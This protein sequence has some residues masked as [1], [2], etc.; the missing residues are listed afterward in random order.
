MQLAGVPGI[1]CLTAGEGDAANHAY[2]PILVGPA[3]PLSRDQLFGAL[4]EQEIYARRYFYPLISDFPMYRDM[5]SAAPARL[6]IAQ[7][8]S[9]Q[10]ICLP[11]Y[12]GLADDIVAAIVA[13]IAAPFTTT[14]DS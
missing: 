1:H 10:V 5:P 2:F 8:A 12:P 4:R 3:Y 11:I 6:P 13:I 9:S 14:I 7:R